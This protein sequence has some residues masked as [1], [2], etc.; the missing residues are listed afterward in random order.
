MKYAII[1][2]KNAGY[3]E[4]VW[5]ELSDLYVGGYEIQASARR[6]LPQIIGE[7]DERYLER[8]KVAGYL[9][10]FGQ[11]VDHFVANLFSS[12]IKV[13]PRDVSDPAYDSRF[14]R[15]FASN[16]DMRGTTLATL[17]RRTLTAA[18][19]K[20]KAIVGVDFPLSTSKALNRAE[21]DAKGL[22]RAYAFEIP[23]E[24]LIDWERDDGGNLTLAVIKRTVCRRDSLNAVRSKAYDEFKVWSKRETV[25]A[26]ELFRSAPYTPD[27]PPG[28]H[29]DVLLVAEGTT[30][31]AEIPILEMWLPAGLWVGNK[32]GPIAKEH[33]QRRNI[34]TS[35]ENKS[36]FAIPY[37]ALGSEVGSPNGE[38]PSEAQ[39][40]PN[41]GADPRLHLANKGY[42]VV[43]SG[44]RVGFAEPTG[45]A[46]AIVE[47]QLRDLKDEMFR[48]VHQMAASV[49]NVGATLGRSGDSKEE[50]RRATAVVLGALGVIVKD[51][52]KQIYSTVAAMRKEDIEWVAYGL[53]SFY[54]EPRDT[55][56]EEA[57]A[58]S[59]VSIPSKTFQRLWANRVALGLLPDIDPA[60]AQ[61]IGEE[62]IDAFA[63]VAADDREEEDTG[64]VIEA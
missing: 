42:L 4:C 5:K 50:D 11:I 33:F 46:Y 49:S 8:T 35:A 41:R 10:Y 2:Q 20:Q 62:L 17:L 43:G 21:E 47:S 29:D 44:D 28:P 6:Y 30:T 53:D 52:A 39:S 3:H 64:E 32:I 56:L 59:S 51:H 16:V 15:D 7:T 60:D 12:E 57:K 13:A 14:Y 22:S 24:S 54:A 63:D 48:V 37:V 9:A 55:V 26:W 31:F 25:V 38:L 58:L 19:I 18:L 34:L 23:V 45:V 36:L 1:D 40:N 27:S 61:E